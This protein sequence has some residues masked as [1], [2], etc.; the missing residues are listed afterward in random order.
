MR[1]QFITSIFI[2]CS[3]VLFAN[4]GAYLTKGGV[5]YPTTETKISMDKEHLSFKVVDGWCT[6]NIAFEFNNPENEERKVTVGFQAPTA[7]G[8]VD[9]ETLA[10]NMIKDFMVQQNGSILPYQLQIAE[11]ED[12]PL[13]NIGEWT[14]N[15]QADMGV[16]VYLFEIV[17]KPGITKINHSYRFPASTMVFKHQM[18]DYILTTGS[19]WAGGTIKDLT[20][21][22][23]LGSNTYFF[24]KDVFGKSAD[25]QIIGTGKVTS[26]KITDY[27]ETEQRMIRVLSGKLQ[28][29]VNNLKPTNNIQFGIYNAYFFRDENS[30][31][32]ESK[33]DQVDLSGMY[34]QEYEIEQVNASADL[35]LLRN[36]I[37]AKYGLTFNSKDL[38]TY[39]S[40]FDWYIPNPNLKQADI[41]L[42]A[43]E[44]E[45]LHLIQNREKEI[46][47]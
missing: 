6:A 31:G 32:F 41:E 14:P 22:M 18:Y 4:D 39:F 5:F 13:K 8:D 38:Q 30:K 19:K 35:R 36:A 21:E 3:I 12:C 16:Y 20:V 43:E 10:S 23:D 34:I 37:Y 45:L 29:H 33:K 26:K 2:L 28:I 47:K 25:W 24:V 40:Q 42:T 7:V 15:H 17:F 44:T 9:E 27:D 46:P 11:C 1:N